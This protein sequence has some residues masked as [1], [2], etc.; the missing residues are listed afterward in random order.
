M[1]D[2]AVTLTQTLTIRGQ[3]TLTAQDAVAAWTEALALLEHAAIPAVDWHVPTAQQGRL[4]AMCW[5]DQSIEIG[6]D[7]VREA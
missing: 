1:P 7:D 4:N 6:I 5:E 2:Y 3:L